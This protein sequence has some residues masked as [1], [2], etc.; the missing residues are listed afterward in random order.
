[1]ENL[2]IAG[3][4]LFIVGTGAA[5]TLALRRARMILAILTAVIFVLPLAAMFPFVTCWHCDAGDGM[6]AGDWGTIV[7]VM[8]M[9]YAVAAAGLLWVGHLVGLGLASLTDA[10]SRGATPGPRTGS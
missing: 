2:I 1:M 7:F 9:A 8:L 4:A 5:V 10:G 6:T 3:I